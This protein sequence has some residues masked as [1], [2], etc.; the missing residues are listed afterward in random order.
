[1]EIA[2]VSN[3]VKDTITDNNGVIAHSLGGPVCYCGM[4][5][6][7]LGFKPNLVSRYRKD[8]QEWE[9]QLLKT[10]GLFL[11]PSG[12]SDLKTT[13]FNIRCLGRS[14]ELILESNCEKLRLEDII[15]T[16]HDAWLVSPVFDEVPPEV[17]DYIRQRGKELEFVMV[18]PQG[19]T[20][21]AD[22]KGIITVKD[23]I[24]LDLNGVQAIK[25]DPAELACLTGGLSGFSGMKKIL[26]HYGVDFVLNTEEK[27]IH[28]ATDNTIY[29]LTILEMTT[30]DATGIGDILSATFACTY[31]KENDFIWGLCFAAGAVTASLQTNLRGLEKIPNRSKVEENASYFYNTLQFDKI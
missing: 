16:H 4:I 5:A 7:E 20:R 17:L 10:K 19:F 31:L 24:N 27:A 6:K 14:R 25:L 8:L 29:S 3:L 21:I 23:R 28:L 12:S 2:I 13:R 18:D 9:R 1:M 22:D 26:E 30:S 11:E 15:K